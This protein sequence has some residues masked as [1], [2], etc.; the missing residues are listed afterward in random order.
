MSRASNGNNEC[1]KL[2]SEYVILVLK[3]ISHHV[4][5]HETVGEKMPTLYMNVKY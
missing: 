3:T 5:H 4:T 2:T 1:T